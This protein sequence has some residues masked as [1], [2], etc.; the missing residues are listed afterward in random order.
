MLFRS[1]EEENAVRKWVQ[2]FYTPYQ[3]DTK[4]NSI[5]KAIKY[6]FASINAKNDSNSLTSIYDSQSYD[7][8]RP[9]LTKLFDHELFSSW[10]KTKRSIHSKDST[11]KS[12]FAAY[13][14]FDRIKKQIERVSFKDPTED[15]NLFEEVLGLRLSRYIQKISHGDLHSENV[16]VDNSESD[17]H[18]FLIDFGLTDARHSLI[19]YVTL[20]A[21]IR[22]RLLPFFLP[23]KRI[24]EQDENFIDRFNV[25][26]ASFQSIENQE[27]KKCFIC[28][29]HIRTIAERNALGGEINYYSNDEFKFHYL[30]A[31]FCISLRQI[32]FREMNQKYAIILCRIL[33]QRI[34]SSS[35]SFTE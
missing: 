6:S 3:I 31:L 11:V 18:V 10:N 33:S 27:L 8:I 7:Q 12:V 32:Q 21:S 2:S 23:T 15:I 24:A 35:A 34:N 25:T 28:I 4:Q 14:K 22:F 29:N 1:K 30:V 9:I 19:D 20:E 17:P 26:D 5:H 16:I 13:I